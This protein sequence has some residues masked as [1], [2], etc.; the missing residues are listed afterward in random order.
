MNM[1]I[2]IRLIYNFILMSK[3]PIHG[4][5]K[6]CLTK[7]FRFLLSWGNFTSK[8]YDIIIR[9]DVTNICLKEKPNSLSISTNF[10]FTPF[11]KKKQLNKFSYH[12]IS[13]ILSYPLNV[14]SR[15]LK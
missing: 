11:T 14:N 13:N 5:E 1:S 3:G 2:I 15:N 4:K 8:S 7:P 6:L 10:N 12:A 9:C